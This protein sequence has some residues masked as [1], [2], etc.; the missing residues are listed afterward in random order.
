VAADGWSSSAAFFDF[1]N[2]GRLDL[3]VCR[4]LRWTFHTNVYCGERRPGYREYCHPSSFPAVT[5]VLYRN[6]GDGTFTD[7]STTSGIDR[8][9]G[10]ALGIAVAD[11]DADGWM[12]ILRRERLDPVLPVPQQSR[13][14]LL[15]IRAD[16]GVAV[17]ADGKA[18]AGMGADFSDYDNDGGPTSS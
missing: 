15:R 14:H 11:Y 12:D 4:Y 10:K 7:V 16:R 3:F 2:D 5:N 13:R 9:A 17:N 8:V 6:N 18:F 1:D